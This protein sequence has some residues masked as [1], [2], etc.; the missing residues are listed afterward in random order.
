MSAA[1]ICPTMQKLWFKS[2]RSQPLLPEEDHSISS[3]AK[4]TATENKSQPTDHDPVMIDP[5]VISQDTEEISEKFT[6]TQKGT[7]KYSRESWEW[8][9]SPLWFIVA[10]G[11]SGVTIATMLGLQYL[12]APELTPN[13]ELICKSQIGGDWQT[14]FG[15][16]TLKENGSDQISGKYGYTNFERGKIVGDLSGQIRSNVV[17]FNWQETPDKQPKQ[18]GKGI[19]IFTEGCKKFYGSYGTGAST[20]N[21]GNWQGSRITK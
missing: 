21:F 11:L 19:L 6:D 3:S 8:Q 13:S 1:K 7:W 2:K 5:D 20:S 9:I 17:T 18:S 4:D 16:L 12:T 10:L 14:S 15:K